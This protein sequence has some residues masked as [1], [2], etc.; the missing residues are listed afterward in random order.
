MKPDPLLL[1]V[2]EQLESERLILRCPRAGD[3]AIVLPSVCESIRELKIWMPWA[4]DD[5]GLEQSEQWCRKG[6]AN[7]V[8]REQFQFLIFPRDDGQHIGNI[9]MFRLNWD[10]PSCEIGYWLRTSRCGRGFMNEAVQALCALGFNHF[11]MNRIEIQCD[12]SNR[13]SARVAELCGFSLNGILPNHRRNPGGA[14]VAT[15][16]YSKLPSP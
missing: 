11:K 12:D 7:F 9:G 14:L 6:A 3:G 15:R 5:Y 13:R 16:V 1:D 4:T 8:L 2:P 10:V